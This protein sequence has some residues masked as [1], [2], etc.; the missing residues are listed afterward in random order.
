M[1]NLDERM[2]GPAAA[3]GTG[4][5]STAVDEIARL[6]T[7]IRK[8]IRTR[9]MQAFHAACRPSPPS[10]GSRSWLAPPAKAPIANAAH[11]FR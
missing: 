10:P 1:S 9:M 6:K 5:G 8:A 4:G 7:Q 2:R 3:N 11:R